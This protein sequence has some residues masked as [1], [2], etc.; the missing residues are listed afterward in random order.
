M[1][2]V[3]YLLCHTKLTINL[4]TLRTSSYAQCLLAEVGWIGVVVIVWVEGIDV[5][6]V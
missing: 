2:Q 6:V 5:V 3:F 4:T 1:F